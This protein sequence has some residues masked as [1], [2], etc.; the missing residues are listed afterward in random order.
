[1]QIYNLQI[2][3]FQSPELRTARHFCSPLSSVLIRWLE[4]TKVNDSTPEYL[5]A[6]QRRRGQLNDADFSMLLVKIGDVGGGMMYPL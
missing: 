1:M 4:E 3:C 6:S 5:M 2:S